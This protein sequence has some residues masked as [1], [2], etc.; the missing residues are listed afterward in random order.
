MRSVEVASEHYV[1]EDRASAN[2]N[3]ASYLVRKSAAERG[4]GSDEEAGDAAEM[5]K[6]Q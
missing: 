5:S 2:A 1:A 3:F 6:G 4:T